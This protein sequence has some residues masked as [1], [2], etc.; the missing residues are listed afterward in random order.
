MKLNAHVCCAW[1]W[2][3]GSRL[4]KDALRNQFIKMWRFSTR[5]FCSM[6]YKTWGFNSVSIEQLTW[7]SSHSGLFLALVPPCCSMLERFCFLVF[8]IEPGKGFVRCLFTWALRHLPSKRVSLSFSLCVFSYVLLP[9]SYVHPCVQPFA[10]RSVTQAFLGITR[11][12]YLLLRGWKHSC[13]STL[14]SSGLVL[15]FL[16]DNWDDGGLSDSSTGFSSPSWPWSYM[17]SLVVVVVAFLLLSRTVKGCAT[18]FS[19]A[20]FCPSDR[21]LQPR[22]RSKP[23]KR[24]KFEGERA[25]LELPSL[26]WNWFIAANALRWPRL[27]ESHISHRS[28]GRGVYMSS[29]ACARP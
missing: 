24:N 19:R 28:C 3:V 2:M 10:R 22:S 12:F 11:H 20:L 25:R 23:T 7:F 18:F 9:V 27:P 21:A 5:Y 14:V 13:S 16:P 26:D 6:S 17:D 4:F 29:C 15:H 1:K 8:S